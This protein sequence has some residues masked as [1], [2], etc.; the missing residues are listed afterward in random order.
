MMAAMGILC[1]FSGPID[2][3]VPYTKIEEGEEHT[4]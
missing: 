3:L 1:Q 4:R 2:V